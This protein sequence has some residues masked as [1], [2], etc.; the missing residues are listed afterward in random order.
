MTP[1]LSKN[2]AFRK[3]LDYV[4]KWIRHFGGGLYHRVD[5]HHIFLLAGGLAFSL[6]ICIIPM[7]L[8]IFSIL[9]NLLKEPSIAAEITSFIEKVVPYEQY[10]LKAK[11]IVFSRVDEFVIYKN[12]AGIVGII[13][14]LIAASGLFSGMR[15]TLNTIYRVP[16]TAS[17]LIGKLRDIGLVLIV[18]I[19][20]L[21][22]TTVLPGL[23]ISQTMAAKFGFMGKFHL[24]FLS[25]FA[26]RFFSLLLI[27]I[28]FIFIY[29]SI[30]QRRLP[31]RVI[32]ISALS[33]TILWYLAQRLFGFYISNFFT[34]KRIYGAYFFIIVVAFWIY[35]TSLVFILGAEIGQLYRE[36]IDL[37]RESA[38]DQGSD[39]FTPGPQ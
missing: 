4:M 29:F 36:W 27:F 31:G 2:F 20:F 25:E 18:V 30:P 32:T 22:S 19:Y 5:D 11:D 3:Q 14:L 38:E 10:A 13:G 17:V 1:R 16:P 24:E 7:V 9:G 8:I 39:N 33:A 34:L 26:L 37:R 23:D 21:L 15:T 12:L 6:F 35:Y 28:S